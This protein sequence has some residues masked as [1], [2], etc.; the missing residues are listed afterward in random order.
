MRFSDGLYASATPS[1]SVNG[2]R[3]IDGGHT[4][5]VQPVSSGSVQRNELPPVSSAPVSGGSVVASV[6]QSANEQYNQARQN[7]T[8]QVNSQVSQTTAAAGAAASS[9]VVQSGDS[10]YGIARRAG[11]SPADLMQANG[12]TDANNIRI[13][14]TLKIPA[15]GTVI[16]AAGTAVQGQ[17]AGAKEQLLGQI[18]ASATTVQQN[19]AAVKN[20]AQSGGYS[21]K[22][23]DSL[24]AIAQSH[25]VSVDELKKA[26]GLSNGAIRVGQSLIIPPK[27][28]TS[29]PQQVAAVAPQAT[30]SDAV[31]NTTPANN[32]SN[33]VKPYTPPKASNQVIEEAQKDASIAPSST[34]ISQMRWPVRGRILSSYGQREGTAVNDGIDIM[35][36]EGTPVKAAENGVVIYSGDGL[37]EFGNTVLIRHDNGLVTVYGHNSSI[38]VQ[39]GQKVRRGDEIAKSGMSGNAKSPKLHF[40]VRKNSTPVN[41][42]KYLES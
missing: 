4:A 39:R 1:A 27:G 10:L 22:A 9:L 15:G 25:G 11:V 13:G 24:N 33:E 19:V 31:K 16:A 38:T 23:G 41:P 30:A 40:E 3:Q 5:S 26:N 28:A 6:Q 12:I 20:A 35:V 37:K 7:V 42:N 17:V 2:S 14:Q 8:N 34:G 18:P 29:A 32:Q 21:V 36:P